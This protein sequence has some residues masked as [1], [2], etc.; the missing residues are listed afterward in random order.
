[1]H[2]SSSDEESIKSQEKP[3]AVPSLTAEQKRMIELKRLAAL[4]K[5][6]KRQDAA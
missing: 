1:M 3:K 4:E 6:K 5:K 2:C